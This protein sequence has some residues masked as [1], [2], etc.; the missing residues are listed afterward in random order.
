[1]R[2]CLLSIAVLCGFGYQ[3]QA[4]SPSVFFDKQIIVAQPAYQYADTHATQRKQNTTKPKAASS[5][6]TPKANN[7]NKEAQPKTAVVSHQRRGIVIAKNQVTINSRID[8]VVS[9][10][11]IEEGQQFE[12]NDLLIAFDCSIERAALEE[13]RLSHQVA[14]HNYETAQREA[15]EI[16]VAPQKL[17][18][19][20]LKTELALTK[21]NHLREHI[22]HCRL[23][24]PFNGRVIKISIQEHETTDPRT[25]LLEIVDDQALHFRVFIPWAWLQQFAIGDSAEIEIMGRNYPAKLVALSEQADPLDQSVKAILKLQSQDGLIIGMNGV[26]RF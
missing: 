22:K 8:A 12:K 2:I 16:S 25:P 11:H 24:A 23:F 20:K 7:A 17:E 5:P 4:Q 6:K 18:L 9:K 14:K 1:M 19:L 26:A 13:A 3:A 10:L 15:E 21:L